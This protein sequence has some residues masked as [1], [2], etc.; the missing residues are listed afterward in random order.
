MR[1]PPF[2]PHERPVEAASYRLTIEYDGTAFSGWQDQKNART[3]V[4]EIK[5]ALEDAGHPALDLGGAGRTD[6]G[7]HALA[8]VAH[9]RLA[10]RTDPAGLANALNHRL[11]GS[12]HVLAVEPAAPGFHARH[13][14]VTRSYLYQLSRRRTAFAK[15]FVW[16]VKEPLDLG[17]IAEAASLL[18]GR[19]D[20]ALFAERAEAQTS[21]LVELKDVEIAEQGALVLVRVV[22]SHFLWRMVRRLVGTLVEVGKGNLEPADVASLLAVAPLPAAKGQPAQWTAPASGLFLERVLYGPDEELPPLASPFPVAAAPAPSLVARKEKGRRL[23]R[24]SSVKPR[25]RA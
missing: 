12:I 16:W 2:P 25:S 19:H 20:F 3:V 24:P 15:R 7:V 8:Q 13:D 14:A 22:A 11:P 5:R 23:R 9:L 6:A 17:R 18:P 10:R 4:G 21:T 1:R